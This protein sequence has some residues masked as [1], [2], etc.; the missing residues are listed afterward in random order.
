MKIEVF[1]VGMVSTNCYL[2]CNE[3]SKEMFIV[4]PGQ[5]PDYLVKHVK[6]SGFTVKGILITHGHFDHILGIDGFLEE[7]DV[8]VY[9]C[10]KERDLLENPGLNVS[11]KYGKGHTYLGANYVND[12]DML[13]V[14]GFQVRVI[15][16][17]GHTAGGCCYYVADEGVVFTGD[18]LFRKEVG[19]WDLPTGDGNGETLIASIKEKLLVLPEETVVYPGHGEESLIEDEKRMNPYLQ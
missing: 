9:A 13:N 6:E 18:T 8:P 3:D 4:D 11:A 14:A 2:V 7:F 15:H 17:P 10:T 12:G 19:R 1:V 16:T 5:A